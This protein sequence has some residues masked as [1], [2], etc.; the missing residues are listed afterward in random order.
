MNPH[1]RPTHVYI[2]RLPCGCAVALTNDTGDKYTAE[3]V[4]DF[5]KE[6]LSVN[7]EAW[8]KY[9]DEIS[10]ESTFMNCPHS[11]GQLQLL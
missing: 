9:V 11:A 1:Q 2:G 6:G 3:A 8:Q 5:I 4:K 10:K 7:R